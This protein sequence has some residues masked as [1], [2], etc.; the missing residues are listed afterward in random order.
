MGADLRKT[1]MFDFLLEGPTEALSQ[2]AMVFSLMN[3]STVKNEAE[4][5]ENARRADLPPISSATAS[6]TI[7]SSTIRTTKSRL[8]GP[9]FY[10]SHILR[11][12]RLLSGGFGV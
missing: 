11:L 3:R 8:H 1:A 12:I 5:E 6:C 9:R 10:S 4:G 2:A 7:A